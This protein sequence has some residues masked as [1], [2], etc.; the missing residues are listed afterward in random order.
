[1]IKNEENH[2]KGLAI[3][4]VISTMCVFFT[5]NASA[6]TTWDMSTSGY[7]RNIPQGTNIWGLNYTLSYQ[8]YKLYVVTIDGVNYNYSDGQLDYTTL[9]TGMSAYIQKIGTQY[10][11][12]LKLIVYGDVDCN[13]I[14][15]SSDM[16]RIKDIITKKHT[17]TA[18]EKTAADVNGNGNVDANDT[19]YINAIITGQSGVPSSTRYDFSYGS[20]YIM[21]VRPNTT[22]EEFNRN[23]LCQNYTLDA[24]IIDNVRYNCTNRQVPV[25]GASKVLKTGCEMLMTK[26]S[27]QEA[28]YVVVTGDT[29][30]DGIVNSADTQAVQNDINHVSS[31]SLY[32]AAAA[33]VNKDGWIDSSD[34]TLINK[35]IAGT[36]V[37][38]SN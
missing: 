18:L 4:L 38:P 37:W 36:Y 5:S 12:D 28:R 33:D 11:Y 9:K 20:L 2:K 19:V 22:L 25:N 7:I 24:I 31:L 29:N 30:C 16:L 3:L 17:P 21:D 10:Y 14:V 27:S 8:G 23:L 26:S 32:R 13:G 34:L 15:N 35:I 6:V 1:M